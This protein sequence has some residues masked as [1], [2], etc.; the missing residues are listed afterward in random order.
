MD[1][2]LRKAYENKELTP[3]PSCRPVI[4]SI[5]HDVAVGLDYLH[6]LPDPI[7]HRDVSSANVLLE[8]KGPGKWKTKISDFGSA[9]LV[10][11]AVTKAPGA[12]LYS[13]PE[14]HQTVATA[15]KKQTTKMDSFSYGVLFCEVL[16]CNFP[17]IETFPDLL[18]QVKASSPQSLL[19]VIVSCIEEDPDKRPS[20][21]QILQVLDLDE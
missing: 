3:D 11:D 17:S 16:A 9:N 21:Q 2:S 20:M 14:A 4:L 1:T 12:V 6:C 10:Q 8:P 7:I 18:E 19:D 15:Y 13:A 5:M